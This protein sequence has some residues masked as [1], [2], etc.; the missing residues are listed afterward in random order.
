MTPVVDIFLK[1]LGINLVGHDH[2]EFTALANFKGYVATSATLPTPGQAGWFAIVGTTDTMWVWDTTTSAWVDTGMQSGVLSFGP[3]GAPRLGV[4]VPTAN[5]YTWSMIDKTVSSLADLATRN[6]S[7]L[8]IVASTYGNILS[9]ADTTAQL[10]ADRMNMHQHNVGVKTV[11]LITDNGDGTIN[12]ATTTAWLYANTNFT[13]LIAAYTLPAR[14][15]VPLTADSSNYIIADY[16]SGSPVYSVTVNPA[17][18]NGSSKVLV[19]NTYKEGTG[20]SSII[21]ILDIDLA[22][23]PATRLVDRIMQEQRFVQISGLGLSESVTRHIDVGSGIVYYGVRY[24]NLSPVVSDVDSCDLWYHSAGVWTK[25]PITQYNNTQYDDGTNIQTLSGAGKYSV[26]WIYRF[27]ESTKHIAVVL[28]NSDYSVT[29]AV[30]SQPPTPPTVLARQAILVGRIIVKK[31]E[32][33]AYQIDS[34]FVTS[35]ETAPVKDHNDLGELQGGAAN[36]YYHLTN[37]QFGALVYTSGDQNVNGIKTFGSFPVG[38][39]SLPTTSYELANKLYADRV[40]TDTD[41]FGFL[42]QSETTISFNGTDTF[43]IAPTGTTW[44]YYRSGIKHTITGSK[45]K[46]LATPMVDGNKYFIFIDATDGTLSTSTSTWTLNDTKVPVA[47]VFWNNTLTPKYI[48]FDERHTILVPRRWHYEHHFVEGT[49]VVSAGTIS[50]MSTGS[51]TSSNKVFGITAGTIIDEDIIL[52][53]S[54][55][56]KPDGATPTYYVMYR[57][58][59]TAWSWVLSDMPFKYTGTDP[60]TAIEYDNGGTSTAGT[61]NYF[62]NTYLVL[63]NAVSNNEANPNISTTG[64]RYMIVQGR[65]QFSTSTL[66]YAENFASF[67]LTGF[68]PAEA[69]A[70]YQLTW[71]V[72]NTTSSKGRCTL[73]RQPV[74]VNS[75]VINS[76][77]ISTVNHNNLSGI[78]GGA[79]NDYYHLTA[80]EYNLLPVTGKATGAEILTGTDDYKYVTAKAINDA[81]IQRWTYVPTASY[82]A[83]PA[84]TSTITTGVD[85]TSLVKDGSPI[86]YTI[87]GVVYYGQVTAVTSVLITIRG[88]PLSG[89]ITK[90][91]IGTSRLIEQV[92][93]F[94]GS[95]Y[96]DATNTDLMY[97][98]MKTKIPWCIGKAYCVYFSA[99][100]AGVDTGTEPKVNL[101]INGQRVSTNDSNLG[102]Q[103]T[104]AGTIVDNSA[105]AINTTNYDI[106]RGELITAECSAAGQ[107]G[108]AENL[109]ITAIFVKE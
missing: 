1:K 31:N 33:T 2:A 69:I 100:Q 24:W 40:P 104:T 50:G 46:V 53:I 52:Q 54:A 82:T 102:I 30:N 74:R 39:S 60:Y 34:A 38:P 25:S 26:N 89:D 75:N 12:I 61:N 37:S 95:A 66:A 98:D 9:T 77:V 55:L 88:A 101:L 90:L 42:N 28:G 16:N 109:T 59:T 35:Y 107:S 32:D 97:T 56:T 58:S 47:I 78:Q 103:L 8:S 62:I 7:D 49:E 57:T 48:L 51:N 70:V 76:T 4:V 5:D 36:E 93:L 86:R 27:V 94:V 17:D 105:V 10:V 6:A 71:S 92:Q 29:D 108:D 96:G 21:H 44:S 15:N 81:Q 41:M 84:S 87:G 79:I 20:V 64:L 83:T 99:M 13:G 63:S 45:T 80:D 65:A 91:E 73:S 18:I 23:S 43:T 19:A 22:K 3:A 106:N 14:T 72:N 85:L 67:D 68:P 11:G